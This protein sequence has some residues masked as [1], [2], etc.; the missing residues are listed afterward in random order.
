MAKKDKHED[1]RELIKQIDDAMDTEREK[2][3]LQRSVP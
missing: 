2:E 1:H 3:G